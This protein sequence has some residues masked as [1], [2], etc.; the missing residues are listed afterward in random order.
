[1]P[2]PVGSYEEDID[3]SHLKGRAGKSQLEWTADKILKGAGPGADPT[4]IDVPAGF[5][6]A[7]DLY[8]YGGFFWH[9]VFDSL[10]GIYQ[11]TT[12]SASITLNSNYVELATGTT[13]NSQFALDKQPEYEI[14]TFT[15]S[16][17]RRFKVRAY[18]SAAT[19]QEIWIT[20]GAVTAT[21]RHV[22]FKVINNTLY[23]TV[24]DGAAENTLNCG[25]ISAGSYLLEVVWDT[26]S[27]EF[28]VNGVS[29]GTLSTNIPSGTVQADHILHIK[30]NNA[31]AA[32][33]KVLRITEWS[34]LQEE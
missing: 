11:S 17:N 25:T 4:E 19:N 32:E 28:F 5:N 12:N 31:G 26:G 16:K 24:A 7:S 27:A 13:A 20:I 2:T 30:G 33:D 22:G 9:T 14:N 15:W 3:L 23:G 10:D 34:F 1:M 18:F 21:G 8:G 29:Q 6:M